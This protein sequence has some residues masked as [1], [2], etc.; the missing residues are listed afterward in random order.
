MK[1]KDAQHI[2][3][4][5]G[6]IEIRMN[7]NLRG[8]EKKYQN[9]STDLLRSS[10]FKD[11]FRLKEKDNININNLTDFKMKSNEFTDSSS[12]Q[13]LIKPKNDQDINQN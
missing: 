7:K 3:N 8:Y 13:A 6:D 1:V 12:F 9:D 11:S 2:N 10:N 5:K 4:T